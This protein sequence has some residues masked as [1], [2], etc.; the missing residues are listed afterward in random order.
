MA[1]EFGH[2][3]TGRQSQGILNARGA[4]TRNLILG[5]YLDGGGSA[6]RRLRPA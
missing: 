6:T 3:H 5:D 1:A 4:R 2:L